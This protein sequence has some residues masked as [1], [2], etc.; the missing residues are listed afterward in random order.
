[1]DVVDGVDMVDGVDAEPAASHPYNLASP[2]PDII[3]MALGAKTGTMK[4]LV[5]PCPGVAMHP[6]KQR[7]RELATQDYRSA[8]SV[9]EAILALTNYDES[10][11]PPYTLPSPLQT[12]DGKT[13]ATANEWMNFQRPAILNLFKKEMYG[14]MP[15][16]PDQM[17]FEIL[18]ER[19]DALD[20]TAIRQEIRIHCSMRNGRSHSF[21][22]L[23]YRP[24]N[25]PEPA[26][27]FLGLC[28]KGNHA[29]TDET[30]VRMTGQRLGKPE[31]LTEDTRGI[32]AERWSF[33][34]LVKR[35]YAGATICYH[36]IFPDH[37]GGW[38]QSIFAL[39]EDL[40][41]F[42][43]AHPK[44]SSIGGWAWGLSRGLDC[45]E[46]IPG[47]DPTRI[48]LHGH[49]RLGKTSLWAG[50]CDQRFRIVIS[51]DSG[52]GGATLARRFFGETYLFI[53]NAMPHW[54]VKSFRQYIANEDAMPFDQHFLIA[55]SAPRPVVVA[56]A[57][58]DLWAD[59]KGEFLSAQNAGA[60]YA[61]FGS[62]GLEADAMP[63]LDE[64]V[65]GDVSYHV[66]TGKHD[67]T[68][69]DWQHYLKIADR[70]L[71]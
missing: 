44:Y 16:R 60:V 39:F 40:D 32:Q 1:V 37:A 43:G 57:A 10:Q 6:L 30:D 26:P 31:L 50:A 56:S 52:C 14:Q 2:W 54:F 61:L 46:H 19:N 66:R 34:E 23:L 33:R 63:A 38:D 5:T 18:T 17:A 9:R 7:A 25:A 45:L 22:M 62:K 35:G 28:F 70:Y 24:K 41:G 51:N 13:I 65:T 15:P 67:Q 71:V 58:E 11:V 47:I 21:D 53:V 42:N 49:S 36:D 64:Y 4:N 55:L 59:P 48:A 27:A 3:F 12:A 20:N 68:W 29:T 69:V 8:P